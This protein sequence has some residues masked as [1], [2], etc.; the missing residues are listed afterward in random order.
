MQEVKRAK[1]EAEDAR[2]A[3]QEEAEKL[4]V[5]Q[6]DATKP[7]ETR[8]SLDTEIEAVE[9]RLAQANR[10]LE[11]A[12]HAEKVTESAKEEIEQDLVR[13]KEEEEALRAQLEGDVAAFEDEQALK[14]KS[15]TQVQS[16]QEHM[17]R[18]MERANAAKEE[19][20]NADENLLSDI[21]SQLGGKD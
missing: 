17:K 16:Q 4:R 5:K 10:D 2:R 13:K 20:E 19:A 21:S 15:F 11:D 14:A 3:A 18:I 1:Q 6:E 12:Q 7:K 8:D 9:K